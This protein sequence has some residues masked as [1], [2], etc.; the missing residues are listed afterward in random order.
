MLNEKDE[1]NHHESSLIE[2][3]NGNGYA[4]LGHLKAALGPDAMEPDFEEEESP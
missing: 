4:W 3:I 1:L 2:E